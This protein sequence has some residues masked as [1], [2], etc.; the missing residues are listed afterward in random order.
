MQRPTREEAETV[1]VARPRP[2]SMISWV[3]DASADPSAGHLTWDLDDEAPVDD[4][5]AVMESILAVGERSSVA[6][7]LADVAVMLARR[8]RCEIAALSFESSL[9]GGERLVAAARDDGFDAALSSGL[10][11]VSS[12]E[13]ADALITSLPAASVRAWELPVGA[14]AACTVWLA[15]DASPP[16]LDPALVRAAGLAL[17]AVFAG[18]VLSGAGASSVDLV[19]RD[20]REAVIGR[21]TR[22]AVPSLVAT[23]ASLAS[24]QASLAAELAELRM[25]A[26]RHASIRTSAALLQEASV[27]THGAW[28]VVSGVACLG[29]DASLICDPAQVIQSAVALAAPYLAPRASIEIVPAR[30]PLARVTPAA[31][32]E[33]VV[34]FVTRTAQRFAGRSSPGRV[35]VSA[36][37][38][39]GSVEVEVRA[40]TAHDAANE[41]EHD[42]VVAEA[43]HRLLS[44]RVGGSAEVVRDAGGATRFR[45]TV[46]IA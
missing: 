40:L 37:A 6:E 17:R 31:L 21:L 25:T 9:P 11:S 18:E 33:A 46:P 29:D 5:A 30:L 12:G 10:A 36:T 24:V 7:A 32:A 41:R 39:N 15:R 44:E 35:A 13:L 19:R 45:L 28:Q 26:P 20:R 23:H 16:S 14:R 27:L 2:L 1:A 43:F 4:A 42:E 8:C 34:V 22:A 3:E 38:G